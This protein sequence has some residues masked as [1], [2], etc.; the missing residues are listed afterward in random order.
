MS[1]RWARKVLA[2]FFIGSIRER[3]TW[4]HHWRRKLS[5]GGAN[6]F[7]P[8]VHVSGAGEYEAVG[9]EAPEPSSFW[10]MVAALAIGLAAFRYRHKF[11]AQS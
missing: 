3:I 1:S 7:D 10:M 6:L 11:H 4:R 9:G 5:V 8:G 2:T